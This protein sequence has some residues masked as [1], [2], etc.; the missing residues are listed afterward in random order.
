VN[1]AEVRAILA[2]AMAYDNRR[3]G[4]ANIA[5]WTEAAARGRWT[6]ESALEAVHSHY[7]T[8]TEFLMPGHITA[9]VRATQRQPE[10][11]AA[12]PPATPASE[13]TRRRLTALIGQKFKLPGGVK[14]AGRK[15]AQRSAEDMAARERARAELEAKRREQ[16]S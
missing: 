2:A 5:A 12:L 13:E 14:R 16:E 3:P 10:P 1:E 11:F 6:F 7:A 9:K 4:E 15:H 8:S